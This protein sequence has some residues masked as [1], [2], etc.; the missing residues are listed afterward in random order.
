[1]SLPNP[2]V[3]DS[4][5]EQNFRWVAEQLQLPITF[6]R[7]HPNPPNNTLYRATDGTLKYRDDTGTDRALY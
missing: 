7:P 6:P 3:K 1:M 5:V 2:H 4:A